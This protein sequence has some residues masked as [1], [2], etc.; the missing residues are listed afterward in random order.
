MGAYD[1]LAIDAGG[2]ERRG[3]LEGDSPRQVRQQLREQGLTPLEVVPAADDERGTSPRVNSLFR[4]GISATDLAL[5]TRQLATLVRAAIPL[6]E[7]LGAVAEQSEQPRVRSILFGVRARVLEGH[8]LADGIADF[9]AVFP[10]IFRATIAAGEHS[11]HLDT[12]LERLADYAEERQR[13]Q[14]RL[15]MAMLYPVILCCLAL[16]IITLLLAF[17]IPK[18]VMVF[19]DL[20]GELPLLTRM[21]IT[22]SD[23]VVAWGWLLLGML[24]AGVLLFRSL[25]RRPHFRHRWDLFK[26]RLPL[27]GRVTRGAN[28]ARFARTLAILSA[29]S[30]PVLDALRVAGETVTNLPMR[31]AVDVAAARVREGAPIARSLGA[32]GLF[33]P[34]T[35]HLIASGESSGQLEQM[36]GRAA[37]NQERELETLVAG[38]M[39]IL[40]P[41]LIVLMG[42]IVVTMVL[43]ILMPILNMNE[44]VR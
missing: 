43:A 18:V 9:P 13:I 1:Y 22:T 11:G 16:G 7:A 2:R 31:E 29:S 26:L 21:L 14:Q 23:F 28:A 4:R 27:V 39:G 19:D 36:L 34:M 40:E 20:G 30:V 44:L 32:S 37:D 42:V 12:V 8:S 33:P 38:L 17:V 25:L 41:A 10:E 5:L 6:E 35:I 3:S 15:A 24:V